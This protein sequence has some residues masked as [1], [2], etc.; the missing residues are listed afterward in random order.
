MNQNK[1]IN[2][3]SNAKTANGAVTNHT[4][5][6]NVLDLF[7]LVGASRN[8][9]ISNVFSK[10]FNEH[11]DLAIRCLLYTRDIRG[12]CGERQTFRN[13]F[14][15]LVKENKDLAIKILPKISEIG[16][17]DDYLY[18]ED[19]F[20]RMNSYKFIECALYDKNAL[21]AKWMPREKTK[22]K[23][24]KQRAFELRKYLGFT[25]R[26][27]RKVLSGLS[28]TVEQQMCAKE[29]DD[30]KFSKVPS[31]A[32]ARYKTA[33]NRNC[34]S[35]KEWV[36]SLI[37]GEVKINANAI[38]PHDV[39]KVSSYNQT[40]KKVANEQWNA[41][42]VP[43]N[44]KDILTMVDVSGSMNVQVSG[45]TTAMDIATAMGLF[46]STKQDGPFKNML[47][48]F[49]RNPHWHFVDDTSNII[50]A[51]NELYAANWGMNTDLDK[52]FNKILNHAVD[53]R[54]PKSDMPKY[55]LIFSDMEF[56]F[57]GRFTNYN[58]TKNNF[59]RN[60][61]E[62]PTVIFWNLNGRSGNS[63][64]TFA[65]NNTVLVSGYSP[66]ILKTIM[67]DID[68]MNPYSIMTKTLMSERYNY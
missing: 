26:Q 18:I 30:I 2:T 54:I 52:A 63:P 46:V 57:C 14:N 39:L 50:D 7:F 41:L 21:C 65:E 61:Y 44:M 6:S 19:E 64:V 56:D 33:F 28:S 51:R 5:Y 47:L 68:N 17:W 53:N 22:N 32:S 59:K 31:V 58:T 20:V 8:K 27:Y 48:T 13:L 23:F 3:I 25:P 67:G 55:L 66:Q 60:G 38:F 15:T 36:D 24:L 35:Y 10:A 4:S 40:E 42:S 29:W 62:L 1:F 12:G 49:S 11:Y 34:S 43:E 37:K 9:D 45:Q 16:R